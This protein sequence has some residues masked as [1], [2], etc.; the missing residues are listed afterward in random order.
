MAGLMRDAPEVL[1]GLV[2][3]LQK[4]LDRMANP[5]SPAD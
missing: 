4:D 2:D 1:T 3:A 5:S